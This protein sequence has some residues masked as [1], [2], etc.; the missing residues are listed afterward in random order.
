MQLWWTQIH[1]TALHRHSR[2]PPQTH[3]P[4]ISWGRLSTRPK[5]SMTQMVTKECTDPI[6]ALL[7]EVTRMYTQSVL[8]WVDEQLSGCRD[9]AGTWACTPVL[10]YLLVTDDWA[11]CTG[12]SLRLTSCILVFKDRFWCCRINIF[13]RFDEAI[14]STSVGGCQKFFCKIWV[15][16]L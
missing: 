10:S 12:R 16:T 14:S 8:S 1:L 5:G 4:R 13:V 15:W 11:G 7:G 2:K 3:S 9:H 6:G